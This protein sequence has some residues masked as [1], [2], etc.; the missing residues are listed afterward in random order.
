MKYTGIILFI[1][2]CLKRDVSC[3]IQ[4]TI[5]H[6]A[7]EIFNK[8]TVVTEPNL[9]KYKEKSQMDSSCTDQNNTTQYSFCAGRLRIPMGYDRLSL[10]KSKMEA[11]DSL[12]IKMEFVV[13]DIVEV[14]DKDFSVTVS[15]Y[16]GVGW[17]DFQLTENFV[18]KKAP[19]HVPIDTEVL[20]KIW[21]PDVYIYN[22]KSIQVL[23]VLSKFEGR[24]LP[25]GFYQD[26]TI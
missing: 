2:V 4:E 26:I 10:P 21:H 19:C 1:V 13:M 7:T 9:T 11:S 5:K 18:C 3:L 15:M 17:E 14:N 6:S 22:M 12:K 25:Y 16:L 24:Y 20:S 8:G 23:K